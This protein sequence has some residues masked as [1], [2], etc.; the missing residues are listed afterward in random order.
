MPSRR[1]ASFSLSGSGTRPSIDTTIS[2]DVPHVTCGTQRRRRRARRRCRSARLRR[3]TSAA[4]VRGRAIPDARR[5]ARTGG[6]ADSRSSC[7]RPRPCRRARPP[8]STCC[9]PSSGASIDSARMALPAN[10]IAWPVPPAVPILPITASAMSFAVTPGGR[11]AVDP[12]QHRL[13]FFHHQALRREHVLDF[14]GADAERERGERAVRARVR[15]AADDRHP[16]QRR[17]LLGTDDMDDALAPIAK[18]KIRLGAGARGCWRRASRPAIR[19]MGSRMPS[20][21]CCVGV[22]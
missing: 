13:R 21:Q 19:E 1:P 5:W 20:S 4:P 2:G 3:S 12:D 15:V 17:A 11:R 22:L 6:R 16:G 7:R 14:G 10:S 8:R 18:R 9:T